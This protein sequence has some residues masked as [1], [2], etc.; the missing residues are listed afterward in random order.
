MMLTEVNVKVAETSQF[1]AERPES[2]K[3]RLGGTAHVDP[4]REK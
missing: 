2:A 3:E 1:T 4:E